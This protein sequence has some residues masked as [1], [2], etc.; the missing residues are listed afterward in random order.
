MKNISAALGDTIKKTSA[1]VLAS[2]DL[3][4]GKAVEDLNSRNDDIISNLTELSGDFKTISS[5]ITAD[6]GNVN[7]AVDS[8]ISAID[9]ALYPDMNVQTKN[10]MLTDIDEDG[11]G[12]KYYMTLSA[13]MFVLVPMK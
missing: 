13:G 11:N 12:Q 2:V 8:T 1:L 9:K 4:V 7:A 3:S 6:I 10:V 5:S